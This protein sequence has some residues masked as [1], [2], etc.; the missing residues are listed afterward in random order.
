MIS[1]NDDLFKLL[2]EVTKFNDIT[3][4]DIPNIDLYMDQVTTLFENNLHPLKR[5]SDDKI[6]TKTMINNYSKAKIFPPVKSKKYNKDQIILLSLIY[7]LKQNL[8]LSDIGTVFNPVLDDMAKEKN[9]LPSI[10]VLY[11]SF[12]EMKKKELE[13][14]ENNF[15]N[16]FHS[17]QEASHSIEDGKN[18]TKDLILLIFILVAK[19]NIN[20]RMTEK[21]ID[22]Y[23]RNNEK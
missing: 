10:E 7:N 8:S 2:S 15:R 3:L 5:N 17:I 13:E 23:F 20:I 19:A 6:L 14:Y 9:E 4:S 12:L 1:K 11:D 16:L 22:T 21:I 18:D